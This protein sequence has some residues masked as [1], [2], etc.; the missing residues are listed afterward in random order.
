MTMATF[1]TTSIVDIK[2]TEDGDVFGYYVGREG[3]EPIFLTKSI[4]EFWERGHTILIDGWGSFWA[5]KA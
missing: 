2:Y 3:A 4:D 5:K 1:K